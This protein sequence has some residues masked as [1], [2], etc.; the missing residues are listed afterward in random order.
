M[1]VFI[2]IQQYI[3]LGHIS[4]YLAGTDTANDNALKGAS[5]SNGL[6]NLILTV[7]EGIEWAFSLNPND[8]TLDATGLYLYALCGRY[9]AKAINILNNQAA[10]VP[11]L[12]GPS[13]QSVNV[14]ATAIF[15]VSVT[16]TLPVIF[17]WFLNGVIIPGATGAT[18][19]VLNA[20]LSQSGSFYSVAVTNGAG[21]TTSS[22]AAL[23]VTS[24][25]TGFLYYTS[26]NPGPTLQSN[27]D[28]FAYQSNYTITHNSPISIPISVEAGSNQFLVVKVPSTESAKTTWFSTNLDQGV[29]PP[30]A[31]FVFATPVTFG[32]F[33][34]Y[35]TKQ[36]ISLDPS[37]PLILS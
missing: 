32:G 1:A 7:T 14:G 33:T 21:T 6:R 17:Q 35:F 12:S 10:A 24:V 23:T 20:Q 11:I 18:Y 30:P 5:L 8:P 3:A 31:D 29:I 36:L 37:Q 34:Y 13:N 25:I 4:A 15:S 16:S 26:V 28:P 9:V 2:P 22:Q 19:S 27:S